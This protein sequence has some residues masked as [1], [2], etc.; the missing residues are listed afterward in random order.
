MTHKTI[1]QQIEDHCAHHTG[2]RDA[3]GKCKAGVGYRELV[4]GPDYGWA[5]RLPCLPN[6]PLNKPP[7]AK[8][9]KFRYPTTEE[10]DAR[11]AEFKK[12]IKECLR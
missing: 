8:C 2:F 12:M 6:S 11:E 3:T 1:R 9:G 7:I 5:A 4:G 10:V